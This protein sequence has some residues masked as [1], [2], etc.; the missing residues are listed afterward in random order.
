MRNRTFED[1]LV[2]I[3]LVKRRLEGEGLIDDKK[4]RADKR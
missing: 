3:I 2:V 4:K 1:I